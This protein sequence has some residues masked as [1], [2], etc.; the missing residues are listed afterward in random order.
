MLEEISATLKAQ[1]VTSA[2]PGELDELVRVHTWSGPCYEYAHFTDDELAD[3]IMAVHD[4]IN[5]WTR[6]QL[7]VALGHWRGKNNDI[8]S[9]KAAAGMKSAGR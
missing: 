6:D 2:N 1:G 9:G 7:V 3:G 5:G 8:K 4:T